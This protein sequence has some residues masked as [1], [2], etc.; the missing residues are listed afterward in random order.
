VPLPEHQAFLE[1]TTTLTLRDHA[2]EVFERDLSAFSVSLLYQFI[3]AL[4]SLHLRVCCGN[5]A[6]VCVL[7]SL[8]YS[9]LDCD[10]LV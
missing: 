7:Y 8:P 10:H 9:G 4:S 3:F 2:F 6:L 1:Y 5:C